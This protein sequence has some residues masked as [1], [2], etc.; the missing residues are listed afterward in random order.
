MKTKSHCRTVLLLCFAAA[1]S[2]AQDARSQSLSN[3]KDAARVSGDALSDDTPSDVLSPTEWRRVD[4]GVERALAFLASQQQSDGSF[5]TMPHAQPGVTSLCVLAFMAHGHN[6]GEGKY[7]ERLERATNFIISCQKPNGLVM[8]EGPTGRKIS[9]NLEHLVGVAGAYNH[10][11]SSLTLS[12]MYGMSAGKKSTVIQNG[13]TKAVQASLIMQRWPKRFPYD[14]G[15]W[16]YL[17]EYD[18]TDSDLSVTGWQLMFLR[19]AR[20]AGFNVPSTAIDDAVGYVRRTFDTEYGTFH[21]RIKRGDGRS[22]GMTG[23]G[24]LALGHAGFHK[25]VEA[26][27]AGQVLL[28]YS[29]E[30]YNDTEPFPKRDRYHYSLFNCCQGMYQL[31]SPYWEEFFPRTVNAVLQHQRPDGSWDAERFH[32]DRRYGNSY[33]TALVILA[34]GAPNQFLPI[35]QR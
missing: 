2:H 6:P 11:I 35:F 34:L 27:R 12:E 14:E 4:A 10:A 28:Q 19:S 21:Y 17:I 32:R 25:S 13:I 8:L 5:P 7:G 1:T 33:T 31:G 30:V 3:A 16:R 15:G 29:F 9:R 24:I 22:R 26:Q 23:A 20:N 18:Q